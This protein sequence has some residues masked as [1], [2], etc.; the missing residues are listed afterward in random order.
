VKEAKAGAKVEAGPWARFAWCTFDWA[1]SAFPTV[2]ITFVFAAY[3]TKAVAAD[4]VTGTSHW[5]YALSLSALA[6][7]VTGPVL[8]AIAD[9]AGRRKPWVGVFSVLCI[10]ATAMLWFAEPDPSNVIWVLVFAALANFAFETGMVFYNAMLPALAPPDKVGRLSGWGWGFGYAGGLICLVVALVVLVQPDPPL[11]GLDK[12][13]FEPVRATALLVAGWFAVFCIPFFL[14]VPDAPPGTVSA[15]EAVREG[16]RMLIGTFRR[17]REYRQ[18]ALFLIARMIYTDGL[19]TLFS[20]GGI[21]AA[22]TFGMSFEEIL[23]FGIAMN[24]TAGIGAF[25]FG[26]VDDW[27]GAKRTILI[28]VGA[29]TV[30]GAALLVI[31]SKTLFWVCALPLGLFF[32][33]AQSASRS[34]MAR[35]APP[36]LRAEMFGLYALSGKATAFLGPAV[37]GWVTA[38]AQSQRVGLATILVFFIVGMLLLLPVRD[39]RKPAGG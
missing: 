8:G 6:V 23:I 34:L 11:F 7:A 10:T 15:A 1:N 26:W 33:P 22:V 39:P 17:I 4:E 21:Y 29:L 28:A 30:L 13:T 12:E 18:I 2:I 14:F 16:V 38:M 27:I 20:V 25:A 3:F 36:H 37:F 9:K 31:E 5:A 24:V 32:G 35:V 19:N